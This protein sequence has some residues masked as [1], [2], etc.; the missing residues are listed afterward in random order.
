[1]AVETVQ[2]LVIGVVV[3]LL[4]VG[5]ITYLYVRWKRRKQ[6]VNAIEELFI[7][8]SYVLDDRGARHPQLIAHKLD[9]AQGYIEEGRY[10]D[11]EHVLNDLRNIVRLS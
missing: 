2:L 5:A 10:R 8:I 3:F 6:Y 11:A 7:D 1:M 4:G 9:A